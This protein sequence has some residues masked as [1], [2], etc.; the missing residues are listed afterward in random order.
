MRLKSAITIGSTPWALARLASVSPFRT[1]TTNPETFKGG[2][3]RTWPV[4]S[5]RRNPGFDH[6]ISRNGIFRSL[7][8]DSSVSP[9]ATV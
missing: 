4:L 8:I 2:M 9:A 3:R 6:V 1:T 7:A 5:G